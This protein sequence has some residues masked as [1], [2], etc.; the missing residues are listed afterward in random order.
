MKSVIAKNYD[1]YAVTIKSLPR[2][3]ERGEGEILHS[4]RNLLV[5]VQIED[6]EWV[7]KRFKVPNPFQRVWYTL[8]NS[9]AKRAYYNAAQLQKLGY[10][11]PRQVAYLEECQWGVFHTGYYICQWV[12]CRPLADIEYLNANEAQ[13]LARSLAEFTSQMH[14]QGVYFYDYNVGNILCRYDGDRW[15]FTLVD[16]NRISFRKSALGIKESAKVLQC[17]H[18]PAMVATQFFARYAELR[19]WNWRILSGV[20]LFQQGTSPIKRLKKG[21]K[22]VFSKSSK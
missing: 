1:R 15:R 4:G 2:L 9:K 7:V 10:N 11:T 3:I 20:I 14:L 21:I 13:N 18:L 17:L 5:K 8:S 6:E 16:I 22:R 19:G 12:A